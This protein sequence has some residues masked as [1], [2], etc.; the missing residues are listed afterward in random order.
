MGIGEYRAQRPGLA[1]T[2][3]THI[4]HSPLGLRRHAP[5]QLGRDVAALRTGGLVHIS[6]LKHSDVF[7]EMG[8]CAGEPR[9]ANVICNEECVLI[10]TQRMHLIPLM[11]ESPQILET[12]GAL[13]AQRR[14]RLHATNQERAETRRQ[15]LISRMQRLFIRSGE[16]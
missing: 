13:M 6:T 5:D 4:D 1:D 15:A 16:T 14:Q 12:M 3:R 2:V 10:E 8:L 11:E 9:S 7:G